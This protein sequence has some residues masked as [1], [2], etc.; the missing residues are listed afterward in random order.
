MHGSL[1][2]TAAIINAFA[3]RVPENMFTEIQALSTEYPPVIEG[4][5]IMTTQDTKQDNKVSI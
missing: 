4:D 2:C 1:T 5:G 3:A